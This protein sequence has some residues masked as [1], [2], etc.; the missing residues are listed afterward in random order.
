VPS[1][2]TVSQGHPP[3]PGPRC[4]AHRHPSVALFLA[5]PGPS[6][7]SRPLP[8]VAAA[9][10]LASPGRQSLRSLT[11]SVLRGSL[12]RLPVTRPSGLRPLR[13]SRLSAGVSTTMS[14]SDSSVALGAWFPLPSQFRSGGG[15]SAPGAAEVSLGDAHPSSVHPSA[16]HVTGSCAGLRPLWQA[17]PP[18]PPNRVHSRS[19]LE[20]GSDPSPFPHGSQLV[21][22]YRR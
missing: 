12:A 6:L 7:A 13:S 5:A 19:G 15:R 14:R 16:N 3:G 2:I 22:A 1:P 21:S 18:V 8:S 17:G 10:C 4:H 20:F 9:V 11:Y